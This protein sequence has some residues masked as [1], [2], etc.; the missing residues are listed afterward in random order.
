MDHVNNATWLFRAGE[1]KP[2]PLDDRFLFGAFRA[3]D[4]VLLASASGDVVVLDQDL[5]HR[6]VVCSHRGELTAI[7][8]TTDWLVAAYTDR[9][10]RRHEPSGREDWLPISYPIVRVGI[11]ADGRVFYPSGTSVRT[12]FPEGRVAEHARVPTPL[13]AVFAQA[14]TGIALTEDGAGYAID[15]DAP[16]KVTSVLPTGAKGVTIAH[17]V[18]LAVFQTS[19]DNGEI[20]DLV[21][22]KR[23]PLMSRDKSLLLRDLTMSADGTIVMAVKEKTALVWRITLPQ[24]AAE[25]ARWLDALTNASADLGTTTLTWQ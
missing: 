1:G 2:A 10:W 20:V 11:A 23:W 4:S 5:A 9:L 6:T 18:G 25:T 14:H 3:D 24:T 16:G 15:L 17:D 8:E 12:W 19:G 22:G 21:A 7:A 13:A